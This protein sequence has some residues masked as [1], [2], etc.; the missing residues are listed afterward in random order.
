MMRVPPGSE[1]PAP[2]VAFEVCDA[3]DADPTEPGLCAGC[4]WLG[5]EHGAS[6]IPAAA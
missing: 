4:G 1:L 3:F 2:D 5:D 6:D